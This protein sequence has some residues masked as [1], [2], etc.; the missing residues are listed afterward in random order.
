MSRMKK[1]HY[2]WVVLAMTFVALLTSAAIRAT[3]GVLIVPFESE[4]GWSR[5]TISMAISTNLLLYGLVGPF[6]AGIINRYGPRRVMALATFMIGLGTLSTIVMKQPWQLV[7]LW[8][9]LVGIGTGMVAVVMGATIVQRWFYLHRGLALGLLTASSATGQL[10]FLPLLAKIVVSSGWRW[11]VIV[12]SVVALI[13]API[14][15]WVMRDRPRDKGLNPLGVPESETV[16]DSV[17]GNPFVAALSALKMASGRREFWILAGSFFVCGA[18]T[19]GLVGTHLI[20]AC[21]DHGIPEVQA[22]G[23]L[24]VMGI[25]DLIGTTGS[26][27][28]SD[29][30]DNRLLLLTYYGFRGLALLYLPYGFVAEGHG[31]AIFAVFYGLDWIATVPPTVALTRQAFGA[32]KTSLVFGWILAAHQVGAALA[33]TFAGFIRTFQGSYDRAFFFAGVLC[34]ISAVG[35]LF[36]AK[37]PSKPALNPL[38][39]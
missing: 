16:S 8:G 11:A 12:I 20:P 17:G 30:F 39:G 5:A 18:S 25:F 34:M 23:L 2:A 31:L 37:S 14:A 21:M 9:V 13:V 3:P 35:V 22:A 28:L 19:N 33:A 1:L 24:A 38:P 15:F 4:F 10:V 27:W 32:E 7:A 26:G 6:A 29:R 36:V